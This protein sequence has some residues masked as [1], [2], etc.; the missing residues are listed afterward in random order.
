VA[1]DLLSGLML[2]FLSQGG[3]RRIIG[4]TVGAAII[5]WIQAQEDLKVRKLTIAAAAVVGLLAAMQFML[6]IR[7]VGYQEFA[8]RGESRMT[9]STSTTITC[10]SRRSFKSCRRASLRST[11][12]SGSRWCG[13]CRR[14]SGQA[15]PS[16]P[17]STYRRLSA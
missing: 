13:R 1:L 15:S 6:N 3:G 9:I 4:V 8:F 11:S 16:I 10:G 14:C 7:T 2:A 5:V 12:S 17:V